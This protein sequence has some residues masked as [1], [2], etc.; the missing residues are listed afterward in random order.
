MIY[1]EVI[2]AIAALVL[3]IVSTAWIII[4]LPWWIGVICGVLGLILSIMGK[5]QNPE[6]KGICTAGLVLSI[7]GLALNLIF[8]IACTACTKAATSAI[9][10]AASSLSASLK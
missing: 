9:E 5:K 2:M 4:P 7:I 10:S 8:F 6:K 3:G 1:V